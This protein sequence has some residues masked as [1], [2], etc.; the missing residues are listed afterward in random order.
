MKGGGCP[1]CL[2]LDMPSLESTARING[3]FPLFLISPNHRCN[4]DPLSARRNGT[5]VQNSC[6]MV[7]E[8]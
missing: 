1:V 8:N 7:M 6:C 2:C 5:V 3:A 4:S